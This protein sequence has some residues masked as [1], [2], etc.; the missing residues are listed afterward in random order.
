[1]GDFCSSILEKNFISES[2]ALSVIEHQA[3][4]GLGNA[5]IDVPINVQR[6]LYQNQ[7]GFL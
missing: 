2:T 3:L 6:I 7:H 1:M 4:S 5:M